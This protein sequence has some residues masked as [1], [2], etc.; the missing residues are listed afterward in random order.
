MRTNGRD[1]QVPFQRVPARLWKNSGVVDNA[2]EG[3]GALD[4][5]TLAC[6]DLG[7]CPRFVAKRGNS[8]TDTEAT[9]IPPNFATSG[10]RVV[11][12]PGF[13]S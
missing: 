10:G 11:L 6:M 7:D 1:E 12:L 13:P 9:G 2:V 4:V 3:E 8:P 5:K